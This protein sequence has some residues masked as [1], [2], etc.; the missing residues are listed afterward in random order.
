MTSLIFQLPVIINLWPRGS[1]RGNILWAWPAWPGRE[2]ENLARRLR[3]HGAR[4]AGGKGPRFAYQ[5]ISS[6]LKTLRA[7]W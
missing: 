7:D 1:I 4:R 6:N 2:P 3:V 5:V